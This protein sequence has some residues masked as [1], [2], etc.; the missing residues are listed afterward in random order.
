MG[1]DRRTALIGLAVMSGA[2]PVRAQKNLLVAA[3]SDL[4]VVLPKLAEAFR[5]ASGTTLAISFGSTGNLARQI[6]QG[7][8]FEVFLAADE[9]F[10]AALATDGVIAD[11]GV[12]YA[13]G[14]LALVAGQ[15]SLFASDLSLA[16]VAAMAKAGQPFR[17]AIA[18]PEHA[19]YGRR[20]MEALT[21]QSVVDI[22]KPRLV[23]GETAAQALQLVATG[24]AAVGLVGSSMVGDGPVAAAVASSKLPEAWHSPIVQRLAVTRKGG[25]A[26]R[27]FATDMTSPDARSILIANGFEVPSS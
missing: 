10:I 20:A 11:Q 19:P 23:Y 4:Q 12:V 6:R 1:L 8:P 26:A 14:R 15:S 9:S 18:N 7:A 27:A 22:L 13:R 24:A 3:A 21:S 25:A 16:H 17:F 2:T 5:Q